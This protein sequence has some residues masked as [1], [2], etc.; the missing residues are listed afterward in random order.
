MAKTPVVTKDHIKEVFRAISYLAN[1]KQHKKGLSVKDIVEH[2]KKMDKDL[3]VACLESL[4]SDG[5]VTYHDTNG[6]VY[7]C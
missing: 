4:S 6:V 7:I 2:I 1:K 3:V 5:K